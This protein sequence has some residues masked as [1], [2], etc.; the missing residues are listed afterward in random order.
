[1]MSEEELK[2]IDDWSFANRIRSRGEAIRRLC[3]IGIMVTRNLRTLADEPQDLYERHNRYADELEENRPKNDADMLEFLAQLHQDLYLDMLGWS[4]RVT[5]LGVSARA[6]TKGDTIE[7]AVSEA[8][9]LMVENLKMADFVVK[10]RV[11][12]EK[13]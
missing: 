8:E 6:L 1:M 13:D 2:S 5:S 10:D 9:H 11:A 4:V 3:Q 7:E 12:K